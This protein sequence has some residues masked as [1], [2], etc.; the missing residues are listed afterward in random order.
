MIL[1]DANILLYAYD[2]ESP[3]HTTARRWLET[4]MSAE[5]DVRLGLATVLAFLRIGTDP[6]VYARP[7]SPAEAVAIVSGL[8]AR[9]NVSLALPSERHWPLL[10]EVATEAKA[11]GPLLMDAHLAALT[12]EHGATLATTDRDF[13]RFGRVTAID[14]LTG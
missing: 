7:L 8:L 11:R 4:T 10:A 1:V 6:R 2:S 5:P 13:A 9:P 12:I 3:D 14:P